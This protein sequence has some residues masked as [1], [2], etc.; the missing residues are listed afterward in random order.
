[1]AIKAPDQAQTLRYEGRYV[2]HAVIV[3][4]GRR[5][6]TRLQPAC[7]WGPYYRAMPGDEYRDGGEVTCKNCLR[8]RAYR[9][10]A[11]EAA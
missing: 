3:Y 8:S 5:A 10:I 2:W 4:E 11:L 6:L 9:D 7:S 1:M